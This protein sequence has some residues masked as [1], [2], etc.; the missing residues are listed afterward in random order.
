MGNGR[1]KLKEDGETKGNGHE[2][3]EILGR[4][5]HLSHVNGPSEGWP[6]PQL[7]KHTQALKR[8]LQ[9]PSFAK[10][11]KA[12]QVVTISHVCLLKCVIN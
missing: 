5:G 7:H 3:K 4:R 1:D 8:C 6:T 12:I 11:N 9:T 2:N 10:I